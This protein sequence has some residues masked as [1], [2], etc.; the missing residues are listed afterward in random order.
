MK[1]DMGSFLQ[2]AIVVLV[3]MFA[4]NRIPPLKRIIG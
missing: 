4:A 2:T 1:F 3:V